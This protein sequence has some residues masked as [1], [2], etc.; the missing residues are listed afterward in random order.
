MKLKAGSLKRSKVDKPL[1][2]LIEREG[3][4]AQINKIRKVIPSSDRHIY[5]S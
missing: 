1:A 2:R 4:R 5:G 3:E